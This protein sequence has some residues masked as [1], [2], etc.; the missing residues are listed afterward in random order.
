MTVNFL[1]L[2]LRMPAVVMNWSRKEIGRCR[3][4][5]LVFRKEIGQYCCKIMY[6]L[7]LRRD[8]K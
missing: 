2:V 7:N 3:K 1:P 5:L 8:Q 4:E 6:D